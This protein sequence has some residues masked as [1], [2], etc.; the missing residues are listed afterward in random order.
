MTM[1]ANC[2]NIQIELLLNFLSEIVANGR[3]KPNGKHKKYFLF[4]FVFF[5]FWLDWRLFRTAIH[6]NND[7]FFPSS[8]LFCRL[9]APLHAS[10]HRHIHTTATI[11]HNFTCII[12]FTYFEQLLYCVSPSRPKKNVTSLYHWSDC[13]MQ[14]PFSPHFNDR[15][16]L[17]RLIW[18]K[19]T[20]EGE[21]AFFVLYFENLFYCY[22]VL[23]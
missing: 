1:A 3:K 9:R 21:A 23:Q 6:T 15:S 8:W 20:V 18:M 7:D 16:K 14:S 2:V 5:F 12:H 13:P 10:L 17:K 19:W 11:V 22:F 4:F